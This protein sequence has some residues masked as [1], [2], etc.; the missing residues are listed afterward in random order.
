MGL[1]PIRH[2]LDRVEIPWFA[3]GS[4]HEG[5]LHEVIAAGARRVVV[6]RAISEAEDPEAA[7]RGLRAALETE[8]EA[9]VGT[10]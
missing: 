5:N 10:S 7:A 2:A 1:D 6:V 9:G 4:L 3:I 8:A